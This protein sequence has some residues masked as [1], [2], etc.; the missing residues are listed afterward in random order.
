MVRKKNARRGTWTGAKFPKSI[1]DCRSVHRNRMPNAGDRQRPFCLGQRSRHLKTI[2]LYPDGTSRSGVPTGAETS[3]KRH[4]SEQCRG[5]G[6]PPSVSADRWPVQAGSPGL[7]SDS[8]GAARRLLL[9]RRG[10]PDRPIRGA[11]KPTF[12]P[13][14]AHHRIHSRTTRPPMPPSFTGAT[15]AVTKTIRSARWG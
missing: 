13:C 15:P 9:G 1:R 3:P 6:A 4:G 14:W 11:G 12:T 5:W 8:T 7:R 2:S 10:I